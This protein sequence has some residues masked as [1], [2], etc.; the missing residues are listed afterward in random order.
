MFDL[1]SKSKY[2]YNMFLIVILSSTLVYT[3]TIINA[4]PDKN[5]RGPRNGKSPNIEIYWDNKCIK[6]IDKIDWG[7]LE[8]GSSN[9]RIIYIR[10]KSKTPVTLH[11]YMLNF[12][13]FEAEEYLIPDWDKEDY[14]LEARSVI[15]ATL[16]LSILSSTSNLKDFSF[17]IVIEGTA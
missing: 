4:R 7:I 1:V 15:K 8:P 12:E 11:C 6:I 3:V 14:V 2:K 17:D 9:T 13:P 10:N 5:P 16:S